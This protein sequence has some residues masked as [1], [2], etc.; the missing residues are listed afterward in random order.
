M[1]FEKP[2]YVTRP[3]FPDLKLYTE[4]L[5][6]IWESGMLSNKAK[7]NRMLK[8][9]LA[10][11][12]NVDNL[13]LFNNGTTALITALQALH[14]KGKCLT[15]PFTFSATTHALT[16]NNIEPIFCD[17]D[18]YSFNINAN[19]IEE[20]ITPDTTAILPVH[21]FGNPC[22]V[23]KIKEIADRYGLKII[24]DAAHA[25]NVEIDGV[26]IGNFG[27]VSMFSF[28]PTKLFHT[29]E[30]GALTCKDANLSK[31]LEYLTDFGIKDEE[32]IIMPGINGKMNELS[33]A[34]GLCVLK[35]IDKHIEQ[36]KKLTELY[37]ER[38]KD[39]DGISFPKFKDNV[40]R[41]YPYMAIRLEAVNK[42]KDRNYLYTKL[43]EYNIFSR[44]YFY[45]LCSSFKWYKHL[46]Y[47]VPIAETLSNE[48]LCLPL[49]GDLTENEVNQI[50]DIIK[51]IIKN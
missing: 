9:V 2:I 24:Y 15:T 46:H 45:P 44:K 29:A 31:R 39:I 49:Y 40:K 37:I 47:D 17:I 5:E 38:L 50:C 1:K 27:D 3:I 7:Y 42:V 23:Y 51:N 8:D 28:H 48:V 43:K 30:G 26:A 21:I 33:A 34:M 18:P 41:S 19:K 25:F 6:D 16:W 22:D 4:Y 14:I 12:L 35:E 36:R 32:T 20:L 13:A 11:H 10:V